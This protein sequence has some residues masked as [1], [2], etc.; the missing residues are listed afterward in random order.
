V[1]DSD[2]EDAATNREIL[3]GVSA[4][5][6][7]G[8]TSDPPTHTSAAAAAAP[9]SAVPEAPHANVFAPPKVRTADPFADGQAKKLGKAPAFGGA[10]AATDSNAALY[11]SFGRRPDAVTKV[12]RDKSYAGFEKH[13]KGI[14]MKLLQKMGW[15]KGQGLGK[16]KQG[17]LRPVDT[18]VRKRGAGLQDEGERT[19]Q[20]KQ[21]MP[22]KADEEKRKEVEH[23]EEI[24]QWQ[25]NP[26]RA[27]RAKKPKY[28]YKTAEEIAAEG[29]A[30]AAVPTEASTIKVVDMRGPE[31][32]VYTGYDQM[33]RQ[34]AT[35]TLAAPT[36]VGCREL[37]HNVGV[38]VDLATSDVQQVSS[39]LRKEER[40][41]LTLKEEGAKMSV[42]VRQEQG[43]L[44]RLT[45]ILEVVEHCR[46][47]SAS[48][49][50]QLDLEEVTQ[51]LGKLKRSYVVCDPS[52]ATPPICCFAQYQ[53]ALRVRVSPM[54]FS[55][56]CTL[57][58]V[59]AS[60]RL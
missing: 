4:E 20:A 50:S 26:N 9:S 15:A 35:A 28:S 39:K 51:V 7:G 33:G 31:A 52:D 41:S 8:Q 3:D 10:G 29:A 45:E 32:R 24:R 58:L 19:E 53:Q 30:G 49:D 23:E 57:S 56:R 17:M 54:L 13:T 18:I 42:R 36:G 14:G 5:A 47:R 38:Y 21:D 48:T 55:P 6:D 40:H 27:S 59:R 44:R 11:S 1:L 2:D 12:V 37:V 43:Y 34:T 16:G 60:L 25:V 22:N 46:S